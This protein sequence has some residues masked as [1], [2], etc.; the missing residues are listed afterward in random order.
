MITGWLSRTPSPQATGRVFCI[1]NAGGGTNVYDRWPN[2]LNSIDF[3]PIELPGRLPRFRERMPP[4]MQDL[5]EAMLLGLTPVLDVPFAFYGQCWSG[6]AAYEAT[7]L[8]EREGIPPARLF[9]SSDPPPQQVRVAPMSVMSDAELASDVAG[10]IRAAGKEPH[11]ELI[12]IYVRILRDDIE[13]RRGYRPAEN[14]RLSTP[15]TVFG[16]ADDTE[17]PRD[18]L[19]LWH[20]CGD[21]ELKVLPGDQY[22]FS[23]AP[24]E[25]LSM[26]SAGMTRS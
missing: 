13:I 20:E 16:W 23:D 9:V 3:L 18:K 14:V 21:A 24:P 1:P 7:A 10:A 2:E 5:V 17:V 25:L 15:I 12:E 26:I 4:T 11:P 6:V 22:R 19:D 8:A